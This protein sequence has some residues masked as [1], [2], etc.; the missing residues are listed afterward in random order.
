MVITGMPAHF[1]VSGTPALSKTVVSGDGLG[2][3]NAGQSESIVIQL[4]DEHSKWPWR[5]LRSV[6]E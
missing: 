5:L 3:A 4:L 2:K 1:D 6:S